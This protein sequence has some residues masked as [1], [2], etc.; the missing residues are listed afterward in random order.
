MR[1]QNSR[2]ERVTAL[3]KGQLLYVCGRGLRA[4][5]QKIKSLKES[6]CQSG[7]RR[8]LRAIRIER[9]RAHEICSELHCRQQQRPDGAE[10]RLRLRGSSE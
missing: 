7:A 4:L 8:A 2:S 10:K 1:L 3:Q 5:E 6:S 9:L